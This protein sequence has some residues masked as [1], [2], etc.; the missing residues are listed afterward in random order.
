MVDDKEIKSF[1]TKKYYNQLFSKRNLNSATI[2]IINTCNFK[3]I[4]CYNQNLK[5]SYIDFSLFC[6][7]VD[8]LKEMGIVNI[9]LTGGEP[10]LHKNFIEIYNYCYDI[11]LK[12]T[13][14]TNGYYLDKYILY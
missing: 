11:G 7:I 12:V 10:T 13:L 4:H 9:T 5:S 8:Q 1:L 6:S 2:E 14:F 3:C